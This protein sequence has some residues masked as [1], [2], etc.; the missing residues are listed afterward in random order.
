MNGS[1]CTR[2]A[3]QSAVEAPWFV[4]LRKTNGLNRGWE[5][6]NTPGVSACHQ[7]HNVQPIQVPPVGWEEKNDQSVWERGE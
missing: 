7:A 5:S 3:S 4:S 2:A 1:L 6:N